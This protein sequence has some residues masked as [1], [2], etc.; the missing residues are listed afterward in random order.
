MQTAP[1]VQAIVEGLLAIAELA[2][3]EGKTGPLVR[4]LA[5]A[6]EA[7]AARSFLDALSQA[8]VEIN[9]QL[10]SGHVEVRLVG[11][12]PEFVFVPD[13]PAPGAVPDE[14]TTARI[15]LRLS[16]ALKAD[17][18]ATAMREGLSVNS[19]IVRALARATSGSSPTRS[20]RRLSGW[21]RS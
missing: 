2:P 14:S 16:D 3:Q 21:A 5:K 19:W 20:G 8:A 6:I 13:E 11:R 15:T 7:S 4:Q 17:V 9:S 10:S 18:E 12:D 1:F